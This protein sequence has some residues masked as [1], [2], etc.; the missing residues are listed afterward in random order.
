MPTIRRHSPEPGATDAIARAIA[1]VLE[2]GDVVRLVGELGAG[3]TT[4]VRGIAAA[5][6]CDPGW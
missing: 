4:L 3:K 5:M 2:P 6:G 1:D